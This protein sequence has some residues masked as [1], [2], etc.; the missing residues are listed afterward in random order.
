MLSLDMSV[1]KCWLMMKM[2]GDDAKHVGSCSMPELG[3][4]KQRLL[5][6]S[7]DRFSA[8][9]MTGS[10][11]TIV[12]IGSAEAPAFLQ[13]PQYSQLFVRPAR[14]ICRTGDGWYQPAA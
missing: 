12:C 8:V 5:T 10:G 13:E 14:L 7:G 1:R 11:S 3:Q 2:T 6:D 4:L 9:F